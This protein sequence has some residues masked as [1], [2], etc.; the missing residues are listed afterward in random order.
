M[1]RK[2]KLVNQSTCEGRVD[3]LDMASHNRPNS[4]LR[5]GEDLVER[6]IRS[7]NNH[8]RSLREAHLLYG[9][10]VP[11]DIIMIHLGSAFQGRLYGNVELND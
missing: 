6:E 7:N 9:I 4:L 11:D 2:G 1:S 8:L 10:D 3:L 5:L